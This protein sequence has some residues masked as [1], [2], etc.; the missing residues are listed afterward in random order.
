MNAR[1]NRA[2]NMAAI[3]LTDGEQIE[4]GGEE[5]DP[6]GA[7]HGIKE[8]VGGLRVWL[9]NRGHELHDRR[10]SKDQVCIRIHRDRRNDSGVEHTVSEGR[11]SKEKS[12]ERSRSAH[13]EKGAGRADRRTNQDE[14]A[15]GADQGR[16]RYEKGIARADVVMTASEVVPQFVREQNGEQRDRERQSREKQGR[17]MVGE[18]KHLEESVERSSLIVGVGHSKMSAREKRSEKSNEKQSGGQDQ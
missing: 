8:Q 12:H 17:M 11:E 6:G 16:R 5:P 3:E 1:A 9:E 2:H 18:R 7:S 4:C 15:E 13:V 10:H 14:R